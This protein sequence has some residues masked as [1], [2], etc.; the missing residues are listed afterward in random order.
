M[1]KIERQRRAAQTRV[2]QQT[3]LI[4]PTIK[5]PKKLVVSPGY[6]ESGTS[7]DSSL[8]QQDVQDEQSSSNT[9]TAEIEER[10]IQL[11]FVSSISIV[12]R[13]LVFSLKI[14]KTS[15]GTTNTYFI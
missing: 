11:E 12:H 4:T 3:A 7:V 10:R 9:T 5:T 14:S 15:T 6:L 13:S 8:T 1:E 2:N